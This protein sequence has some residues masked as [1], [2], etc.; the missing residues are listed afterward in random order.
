MK[1]LWVVWVS[2]NPCRVEAKKP[3]S[4]IFHI[5]LAYNSKIIKNFA[6]IKMVQNMTWHDDNKTQGM[7]CHSFDGEAWKHFNRKHS[8]FVIH[9]CDVDY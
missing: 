8:S 4:I 9:P 5:L 7:L 2:Q 1:I 3:Y 6:S